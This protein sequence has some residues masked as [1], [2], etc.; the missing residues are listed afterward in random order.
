[1]FSKTRLTSINLKQKQ[2]ITE[3]LVNITYW[4]KFTMLGIF[5]N[6]C[7]GLFSFLKLRDQVI[8]NIWEN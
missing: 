7:M 3:R 6:P 1:M 8:I 5:I 4:M 2:E